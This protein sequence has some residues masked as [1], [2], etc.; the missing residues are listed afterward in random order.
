MDQYSIIKARICF[1]YMYY[2]YQSYFWRLT[3]GRENI[4]EHLSPPWG[5]PFGCNVAVQLAAELLPGLQLRNTAFTLLIR[6]PKN[7]SDP[8]LCPQFSSAQMAS[9]ASL[10]FRASLQTGRHRPRENNSTFPKQW[11][12]ETASWALMLPA[13]VPGGCS[14]LLWTVGCLFILRGT[15]GDDHP[16]SIMA[17]IYNV[18]HIGI[19]ISQCLSI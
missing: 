4:P 3:G 8:M 7:C 1:N 11:S 13:A 6:G 15:V 5:Q 18:L 19:C 9:L 12:L 17:F 2:S 14:W 10:R 16:L